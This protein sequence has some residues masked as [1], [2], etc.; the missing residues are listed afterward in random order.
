MADRG[1]G[2][3]RNGEVPG[4]GGDRQQ[5]DGGP[6]DEGTHMA[7][8][9]HMSGG[10]HMSG[11]GRM[12]GGSHMSGSGGLNEQGQSDTGGAQ[13]P[14]DPRTSPLT[15]PGVGR[16]RQAA[17]GAPPH[18]SRAAGGSVLRRVWPM[19]ALL[20]VLLAVLFGYAVLG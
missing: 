17:Q 5:S 12:S 3:S 16:R 1:A 13:S 7:G 4:S 20:I 18:R 15:S 2:Q 9:D 19:A 11:G 10:S 14:A 6:G 8:G